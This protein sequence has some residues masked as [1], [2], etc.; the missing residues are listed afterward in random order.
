[1]MCQQCPIIG[2][3][4]LTILMAKRVTMATERPVKDTLNFIFKCLITSSVIPC[5]CGMVM[6]TAIFNIL[7][8]RKKCPGKDS[9]PSFGKFKVAPSP[10][11]IIF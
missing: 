2:E 8:T 7:Q 9:Q 11:E 5:F 1:M 6:S 10:L 4:V 3:Q